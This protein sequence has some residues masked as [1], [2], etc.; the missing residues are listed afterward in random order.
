VRIERCKR[1]NEGDEEGRQR[2]E[3]VMGREGRGRR[4]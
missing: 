1:E 3:K 2:E 4:R